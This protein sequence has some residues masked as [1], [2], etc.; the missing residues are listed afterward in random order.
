MTP[1]KKRGLLGLALFAT[2]IAAWFAP[3]ADT[4]G[5]ALSERTKNTSRVA[6]KD[7]SAAGAT[8]RTSSSSAVELLRI[9][10]RNQEDID[11]PDEVELF[12]AT[13]W[14]SPD[15]KASIADAVPQDAAP[16]RP[17]APPLPFSVLGKYEEAGQTAIFL[18]NND[19][20]LVAHVGDTIAEQYKV[21]SLR[22]TTLTLLYLPLN[23]TQS[24]EVGGTQ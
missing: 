19:Q 23:Q 7:M 20:N 13:Q 14:S 15:K 6:T 3:I 5:V 17:Q 1:K 24:L 11:E 18:Q 21:E 2:C 10:A 22:G 4:D 9:H 12:S 8:S 16:V